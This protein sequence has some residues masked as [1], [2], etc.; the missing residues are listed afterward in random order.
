MV[1]VYPQALIDAALRVARA[2]LEWDRK[3][4]VSRESNRLGLRSH[5]LEGM[6]TAAAL[7]L[8]RA[9]CPDRMTEA[10]PQRRGAMVSFYF[11]AEVTRAFYEMARS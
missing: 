11:S 6:T 8:L 10:P 5:Y 9:Q 7:R 1:N 2:N 3:Y 4:G